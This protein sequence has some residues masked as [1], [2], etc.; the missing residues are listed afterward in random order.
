M[1]S[2][3]A[4]TSAS[5]TQASRSFQRVARFASERSDTSRKSASSV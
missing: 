5:R 1:C 2:G 3:A 4:A